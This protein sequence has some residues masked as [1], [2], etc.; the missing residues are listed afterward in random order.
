MTL[1]A[2]ASSSLATCFLVLNF[3][4]VYVTMSF[5]GNYAVDFKR[6]ST[7]QREV[8]AAGFRYKDKRVTFSS[9]P[10]CSTNS[11]NRKGKGHGVAGIYKARFGVEDLNSWVTVVV[12]QV[13][14]VIQ[15]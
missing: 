5:K 14:R 1:T 7:L 3:Q 6:P 13:P 2:A 15:Y 9:T 12:Q 4:L 10:C 11:L 8:E